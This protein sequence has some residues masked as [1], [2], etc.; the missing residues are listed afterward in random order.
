MQGVYKILNRKNGKFYIGS[1]VDIEKRFNSHKKE[2]IAGTHNNKHLQNA[3][4]KYGEDSFEFFVLE[5]VLD[6]NEL[7]NRETYYLQ[8]TECTNPDIGYNLLDNA[9]IGLGVQASVEVRQKISEACS[10][11]KNGNYGR[12]HTDEELVC[13][14]NN[15][16]GENYVRKPRKYAPRKTPEELMVSRKRM[17]E[18]MKNR[19]VLEETR[20]KLRQSRLG[21]KASLELRKKFSENRKGSKNANSKLTKEQVLEIY[22]KMN[23][24]ANYKEVCAEYGI[25]QCWAYKI[26]KKEHWVFN[27]KQ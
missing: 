14:R 2:L 24:G 6:I 10:G 25:G 12:K 13:M 22:E 27:D 4:N 3:W 20:E 5:E 7:R 23:S 19:P 17:S 18:F 11:S 15:R 16:W 26:K 21:K 8:S 9:N 1:S